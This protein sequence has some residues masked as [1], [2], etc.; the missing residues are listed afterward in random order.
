M[1]KTILAVAA[2]LGF[3]QLPVKQPA[4]E[5]KPNIILIMADDMGYGDLGCYG[6]KMIRTPNIDALAKGGLRFTSYYAGN[7][8]CAPSREALLTGK[9]TG[10]TSIRGNFL[11]DEKEDPAMPGEKV[12][13]AELLKGAGYRTALIGKW[14]LG[15]EGHGPETQG[16]DYSY[17][18]LDQIQAHDYYPP[19]LYENGKK[20]M[21]EQNADNKKGAYSHHLFVGKTVEYLQT[22]KEPFF[23]YL[24]YTIPHGD[25]VIP[26]NS[27]YAGKDWPTQFKNYAAMITQLDSDIGRLMQLLKDKGLDKNTLILFTSDNGANPGFAKFFRSN[28]DFRGNKTNLY[29]GG[30]REPLIAYWPGKIKAGQVSGHVAAGWDMLPTICQVAGIKIP[31]GI[32]GVSFYPGLFAEGKQ[33]THPYLYWEYYTYN[34]NWNK[35]DAT[36]PRNWLDSRAVRLGNWKAVVKTTPTDQVG[37]IELYDLAKDAAETTDVATT[38]PEVVSRVKEILLKATKADAPYFPYKH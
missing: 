8:V 29:E 22:S 2:S 12:T 9:H 27:A 5:N 36:Q 19:F 26:D 10:H 11:T 18:Y 24:P 30:I 14:G 31:G 25:H 28:G 7:T 23:L 35:P 38:H 21:L 6:Q 3:L 1:Y 34:Y 16:F 15:G 17:G 33:A 37:K 20:I 13:I 32:D 4:A